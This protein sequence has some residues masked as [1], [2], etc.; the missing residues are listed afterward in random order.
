[1]EGAWNDFDTARHPRVGQPF[2][3][4]QIFVVEQVVGADADPRRRQ[5]A[6]VVPAR[7]NCHLWVGIA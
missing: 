2:R 3:V 7:G 5:P 4:G 1:V 6:E